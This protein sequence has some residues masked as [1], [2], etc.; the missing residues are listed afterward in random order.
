MSA[1]TTPVFDINRALELARHLGAPGNEALAGFLLLQ[2]QRFAR[3]QARLEE[4]QRAC[5][6]R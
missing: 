6:G 1:E 5:R 3:M 4:L 2:E